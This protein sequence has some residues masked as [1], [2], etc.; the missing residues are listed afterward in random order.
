MPDQRT[1]P[2]MPE[3]Y[4]SLRGE[5]VWE[6]T[7]Q[8]SR[9]IGYAAPALEEAQA[10]AYLRGVAALHPG[11][12]CICHGYICG[13]GGQVQRFYDGHEPVGGLPILDALK[14]QGLVGAVCAV[15]R[16][17]GGVKLGAGGLARAFGQ[18]AAMSIE[19]AGAVLYTQSLRVRVT[20]DYSAQKRLEYVLEHSSFIAEGWEF[21]EQAAVT[22]LLPQ[23][24][25]DEF[26]A[27]MLDLTHGA[28][29]LETVDTLYYP[30]A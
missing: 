27:R 4:L 1:G 26:S 22:V 17:F 14:K 12:S 15:V 29:L 6:A 18:A 11:A 2:P 13:L 24:Q 25:L 23:S 28:A 16:Y 8:K 9:F 20:A 5:G 7:T 21:Q 10:Q 3:R 30:W 19:A